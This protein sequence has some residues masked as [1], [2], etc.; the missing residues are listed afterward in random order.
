MTLHS[1]DTISCG[2]SLNA[3]S[4]C[5]TRLGALLVLVFCSS[6]CFA[7]LGV[8]LVLVFYSSWCFTRLGVLLVLVLC[9]CGKSLNAALNMR[10]HFTLEPC[11]SFYCPLTLSSYSHIKIIFFISLETTKFTLKNQIPEICDPLGHIG[12][13]T[14]NFINM[15]LI[16]TW[17]FDDKLCSPCVIYDTVANCHFIYSS[18]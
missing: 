2:K 10:E 4:W 7:R 5:F 1:E 17:I 18:E 12:H 6:W 8:L 16:S 13:V 3:A 14:Y 9:S 11:K 15:L